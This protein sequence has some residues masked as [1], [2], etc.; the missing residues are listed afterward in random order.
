MSRLLEALAPWPQVDFSEFGEVEVRKL[1]RI[2]KLVGAF[3]GR[4]WVAV[5]HV[6]HHDDADI[7][8]MEASRAAFNRSSA[9]KVTP[10]AVLVRTLALALAEHPVFNASLDTASGT[11][12]MKKYVHMG[13]RLIRRTGFWFQ[14]SGTAIPRRSAASRKRYWRSRKRPERKAFQCQRCLGGA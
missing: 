8:D 4:N 2:Q 1:S 7:T 12:V 6:T 9:I 3:L 11:L 13:W 10:V 14:S 5:P